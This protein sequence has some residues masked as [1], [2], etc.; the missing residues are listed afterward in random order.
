MASSENGSNGRSWSSIFAR[1]AFLLAIAGI[2]ILGLAAFGARFGLWNY[3]PGL[4]GMLAALVASLLGL[5]VGLLTL[6]T[7]LV[8]GRRRA[9]RSS[10]LAI[11]IALVVLALPILFVGNPFAFPGIH[12]ITT[13]TENP[14]EYVDVLPHRVDANSVIYEEKTMTPRGGAETDAIHYRD[15]QAEAYPDIQPRVMDEAPAE[16]FGRALAAAEAQGWE[17]IAAVPNE[18]RIEATAT[19]FWFG[20][21][22]DVVIRLAPEGEGTKLDI[23]STSRVGQGDVGA[24][25]K[26]IRAYLASL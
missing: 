23:R 25:A 24:N 20:F 22:D 13:D 3:Q 4:M 5:V 26:R 17:I 15:V 16:A 18:G 9:I 14:P 2:L 1:T 12:D 21:K 7:C 19:T 8:T 10:S 11:I 6:L